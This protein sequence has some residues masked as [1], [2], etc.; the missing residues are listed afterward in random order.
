VGVASQT[1]TTTSSHAASA[2]LWTNQ[3]PFDEDQFT[4]TPNLA[5]VTTLD[6][7]ELKKPAG[8]SAPPPQADPTSTDLRDL[9]PLAGGRTEVGGRGTGDG[10]AGGG[11]R[12]LAPPQVF[13]SS[14]CI[15]IVCYAHRTI[16]P[17]RLAP[18][19]ASPVGRARLG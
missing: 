9:S 15:A 11:R 8:P 5:N 3:V 12:V 2:A 16:T 4:M 1:D 17:L 6:H 7:V 10:S 18:C 13:I 19:G 14:C